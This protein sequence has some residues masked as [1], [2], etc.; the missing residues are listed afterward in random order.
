MQA[1]MYKGR[2][3]PSVRAAETRLRMAD[4]ARAAR[5]LSAPGM[6]RAGKHAEVRSYMGVIARKVRREAHAWAMREAREFVR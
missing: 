1:G 2:T 6:D 5:K 3:W 4:F